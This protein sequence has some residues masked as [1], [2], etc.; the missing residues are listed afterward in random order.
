MSDDQTR[1][2]WTDE[3]YAL[4]PEIREARGSEV[5]YRAFGGTTKR[6][7]NCFFVPCVLGVPVPYWTAELLEAELNA[8]LWGNDFEMIA[9]FQ[10][11]EKVQYQIGPIAHSNYRGVDGG[12]P[13][14]QRSFVTPR[15]VFKQVSFLADR[16]TFEKDWAKY[17]R[18]LGK[19]FV[20]KAHRYAREASRRAKA[21]KQ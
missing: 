16:R 10:I 8:S 5:I 14:Y 3:G 1:A 4:P 13:F 21:W 17:V 20:I 11:H 9:K 2:S 15:G 7:G 19:D 12:Q 6:L 18:D